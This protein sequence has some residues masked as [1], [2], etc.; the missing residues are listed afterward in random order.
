MK[1]YPCFTRFT[2]VRRRIILALSGLLGITLAISS[3]STAYGQASQ[4]TVTN[5]AS[6]AIDAIAPQSLA[7][8]FGVFNTT[9]G[10]S[11]AAQSSTLP[12][13]LGG[14]KVTVGG[15]DAGLLFVSPAQINFLT[16]SQASD[17]ATPVVVTN[18]DGSTRSTSINVQRVAPGIFTARGNGIGAPAALLTLDGLNFQAVFNADGSERELL[19]APPAQNNFLVL[20]T[21]GVRNAPA[22]TV[23]VTIQG[24][25]ATVAF[26]GPIGNGLEQLNVII[27]PELSGIGLAKVRLSIGSSLANTVNIRIGGKTPPIK[28]QDIQANAG[29]TANLSATDQVQDAGDGTGRTFF[30][31]AYKF[32]TTAANTS[33]AVDLRAAQF[34]AAVAIYQQNTDGG[35][36]LVAADDQTGALGNGQDENGNALLLTVL[37]NPGDYLILVTSSDGQPNAT[38]SYSLNLKTGLIQQLNYSATAVAGAIATSDI[39]TSAGDYLDAY[40]FAATAGDFV[41]IRLNSTDFDSFLILNAETGDLVEFND[42]DG[43]GSQGLNAL[44]SI[45]IPVSGNY[46]I[47]ATPFAPGITGSYMLTLNRLNNPG[48]SIST[49]A[50][51]EIQVSAPSRRLQPSRE[52]TDMDFE[53]FSSRRILRRGE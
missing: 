14:V 15:V 20:F 37:S 17:G 26:S 43:G 19:L 35:L 38:G 53:R 52:Q 34:D 13:T 31:D 28:T 7:V 27:P 46:I 24:V 1:R 39:Q 41:Q 23:S 40:W 6:F 36:F 3:L 11:F 16:P 29:V 42:N 50:D 21:T 12:A 48:L 47:L 5:A 25:P 44:L 10:Q 33:V 32:R 9:G 2:R 22:F 51:D 30:F 49:V 45:S 4:V 8:A 18:A